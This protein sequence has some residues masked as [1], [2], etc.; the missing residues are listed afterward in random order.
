M[1]FIPAW[2]T[3]ALFF[4]TFYLSGFQHVQLKRPNSVTNI[5]F[6]M[7]AFSL[8]MIVV[9]AICNRINPWLSLAFLIAAVGSLGWMIREHRMLPP[10]RSFE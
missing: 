9:V 6:F 3:N 10:L 5:Q 7:M 2:I 8:L 1:I 4:V